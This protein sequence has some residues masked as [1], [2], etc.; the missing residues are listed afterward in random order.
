MEWPDETGVYISELEPFTPDPHKIT[1][2]PTQPVQG[3]ASYNFE[4]STKPIIK[5]KINSTNN[6]SNR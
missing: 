2:T 4:R 1:F 3:N 6:E 5:L